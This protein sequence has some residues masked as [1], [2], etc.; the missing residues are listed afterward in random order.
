MAVTYLTEKVPIIM[1]STFASQYPLEILIVDDQVINQRIVT[2]FLKRLGYD[3]HAVD[4]GWKAIAIAQTV[5]FDLILMDVQM[6]EM[7]VLEAANQIRNVLDQKLQIVAMTALS[8]DQLLAL[9]NLTML[10]GYIQKPV[11]L[12]NLAHYLKRGR[13]SRPTLSNARQISPSVRSLPPEPPKS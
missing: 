13:K 2:S 4:R 1:D 6:P 7:N 9:G 8:L 11:T 10:D 12:N 3:P 5:R